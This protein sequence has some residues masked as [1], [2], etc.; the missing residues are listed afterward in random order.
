[1]APSSAD[2]KGTGE[3][4]TMTLKSEGSA[5][6]PW[7]DE[8]LAVIVH[9]AGSPTRATGHESDESTDGVPETRNV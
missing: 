1:M 8:A 5:A 6:V 2:S 3:L 4:A 9:T 7:K